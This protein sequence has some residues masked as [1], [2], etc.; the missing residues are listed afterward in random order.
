VLHRAVGTCDALY[1][2]ECLAAVQVDHFTR[3]VIQSLTIT[4]PINISF[5]M[6]HQTFTENCVWKFVSTVAW[7][8]S[9]AQLWELRVLLIPLWVNAASSVNKMYGS[10][11]RLWDNQWQNYSRRASSPG[12]RC[13]TGWWWN[14]Y[15][16]SLCN[17]RHT[18][19]CGTW[20]HEAI[21]RVLV[22]GLCC[23]ILTISSCSSTVCIDLHSDDTCTLG[24]VPNSRN[25]WNTLVKTARFGVLRNE[26]LL[27]YSSTAAFALPLPYPY[28]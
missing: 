23:A 17:V 26:Y 11:F 12:C 2:R 22:V 8:L 27:W 6:P 15:K 1:P 13:C 20:R 3:N 9:C 10:N 7:G 14:G 18:R 24:S 16:Q 4:G 19:L 28:T 5:I 25:A 21:R